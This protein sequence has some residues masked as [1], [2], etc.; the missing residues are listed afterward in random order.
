LEISLCDN[1]KIMVTIDC[2]MERKG[3][4]FRINVHAKLKILHFDLMAPSPSPII[5]APSPRAPKPQE[6]N[7]MACTGTS[8]CPQSCIPKAEF[9]CHSRNK[10]I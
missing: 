1:E 7:T 2:T 3:R 10:R 6:S 9:I 4:K 5:K 8:T